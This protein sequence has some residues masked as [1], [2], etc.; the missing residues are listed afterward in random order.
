VAAGASLARSEAKLMKHLISVLLL[1]STIASAQQ[2][3][4]ST[5]KVRKE[6]P[7]TMFIE[8]KLSPYTPGLD[9]PFMDLTPEKRP[10][11]AI[12][13]GGPMLMGEIEIDYQFFQKFG[14]LAAGLSVGYGEKF[15]KAL[16]QSTLQRVDQ[17]TGMRLIPLKAL[18]VY[19]WDWA[20]EKWNIP[21]VPYAK[22]AFVAMPYF[23]LS[24]TNVEQVNVAEVGEGVKFGLAGTFG[25]ALELDFIDQ[26]LARDFDSSVGVNHT[27]LFAEGTVQA[28]AL[29]NADPKDLNFSSEHFMFGLGLEF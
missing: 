21:L 20:K 29:F 22:A 8:F 18:L 23:L 15:N 7:R 4:I 12:Y 3:G 19:R 10:Y 27:Y 26:R 25:L 14:S 13:G 2:F 5:T 6:T 16:D 9:R 24:G 17:S 1:G 11:T 28:M